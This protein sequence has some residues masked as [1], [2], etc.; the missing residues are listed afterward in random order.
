MDSLTHLALITKAQLVFNVPGTFL[1]FPVLSSF[2]YPIDYWSFASSTTLTAEQQ[3]NWAEFCQVANS[4]PT[5]TIFQPPPDSYLW[6]KYQ[7]VLK[8]SICAAG[9]LTAEQQADLAGAQS[10]LRITTSEGSQTD[11]PA[12]LAYK[13]C[14]DAWFKAVQDYNTQKLTADAA[15]DSK[16]KAQWTNTDE[17]AL[18]VR[19]AATEANWENNGNKTAVERAQQVEETVG[20]YSPQLIWDDW[21]SQLIPDIDLP[22]D[23]TMGQFGRTELVPSDAIEEKDWLSS[24][25][26]ASEIDGLVHQAPKEL[27]AIYGELPKSSE[28]ESISFEYRSVGLKRNWLRPELFNKC[29]WKF[30]EASRRLSDGGDPPQ[31]EWPAYIVAVVLARNFLL[32][33]RPSSVT[34]PVAAHVAP[35]PVF[36]GAGGDGMIMTMPVTPSPPPPAPKPPPQPEPQVS[37]EVS[38]LCFICKRLPKCPN[39]DPELKW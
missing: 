21:K 22:T 27:A 16:Q 26:T 5:G 39:P 6:D 30:P 4:L 3:R 9:E 11:S 34:P 17:P 23:P 10:Y 2:S 33:T 20:A 13:Q 36:W 38:I 32:K 15:T 24:T 14:R 35:P 18:R 25:L 29:F 12:V 19:V 8:T 31:G 7:E 1:S 28:I 37:T